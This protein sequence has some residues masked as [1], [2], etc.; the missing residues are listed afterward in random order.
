MQLLFISTLSQV[1]KLSFYNYFNETMEMLRDELSFGSYKNALLPNLKT[2]KSTVFSAMFITFYTI[3]SLKE[4]LLDVDFLFGILSFACI[5]CEFR[6]SVRMTVVA[7]QEAK[8]HAK[9]SETVKLYQ[10]SSSCNNGLQ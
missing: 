3:L 6:R 10:I 2:T 1:P 7:S 9:F 4:A 8:S 5:A